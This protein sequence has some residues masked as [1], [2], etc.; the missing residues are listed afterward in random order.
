MS[1]N[2]AALIVNDAHRGRFEPQ[3]IENGPE[4][5]QIERLT[6]DVSNPQGGC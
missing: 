2:D 6:G 1:M 4:S 5:P 3:A